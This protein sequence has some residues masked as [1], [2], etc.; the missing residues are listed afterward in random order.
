MWIS[1]AEADILAVHAE[2][3]ER[4][5]MF[6]SRPEHVEIRNKRDDPRKWAI[7]EQ[8]GKKKLA[9][10]DRLTMKAYK[11]DNYKATWMEIKNF[12][13]VRWARAMD[14]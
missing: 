13:F 9:F 2:R 10:V 7:I 6:Y 3:A 5:M 11:V 4:Y 14:L 1:K 12:T 8:L